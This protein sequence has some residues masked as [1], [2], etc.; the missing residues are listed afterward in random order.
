MHALLKK[1]VPASIIIAF[2]SVLL[3]SSAHSAE[4]MEPDMASGHIEVFLKTLTVKWWQWAVSIPVLESPL[5]DQTEEKC[6]VP[7]FLAG[8]FGCGDTTHSCAIP[9]GKL[10]FYRSLTA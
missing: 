1:A 9:E 5:L 8:N 10:L 4:R 3:A 2:S 7:R 6:A